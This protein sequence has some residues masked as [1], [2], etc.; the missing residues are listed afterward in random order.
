MAGFIPAI[1]VLLVF[2]KDE[3]VDARDKPGDD[4]LWP[5]NVVCKTFAVPMSAVGNFRHFRLFS[6]TPARGIVR[7]NNGGLDQKATPREAV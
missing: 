2:A 4:G 7:P 5:R 6:P 1:H 3:D